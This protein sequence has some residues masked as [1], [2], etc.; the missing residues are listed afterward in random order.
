M[1]LLYF[2]SLSVVGTAPAINRQLAPQTVLAGGK[3]DFICNVDLGSPE[4]EV[5]WERQG[6]PVKTSDRVQATVEGSKACLSISDCSI[7]DVGTYLV[8]ASNKLGT[9]ESEASL[10]VNCKWERHILSCYH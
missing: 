8:R 2:I 7:Q 10:T 6:R 3:A 4:A 1:L 9:V 5:V